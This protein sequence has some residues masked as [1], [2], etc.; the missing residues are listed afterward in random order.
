MVE[1]RAA[2]AAPG[3]TRPPEQHPSP[4]HPP[5]QVPVGTPGSAR[6]LLGQPVTE[7]EGAWSVCPPSGPARP[8]CKRPLAGPPGPSWGAGQ[9]LDWGAAARL[10]AGIGVVARLG[11]GGG[12][13]YVRVGGGAR[14]SARPDC[15]AAGR[16]PEPRERRLRHKSL[17]VPPSSFLPGSRLPLLRPP[18]LRPPL[19]APCSSP[20]R[21][22][23]AGAGGAGEGAGARICR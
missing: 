19:L 3:S 4:R 12:D 10:G 20:G 15:G 11:G 9:R 17:R 8:D 21:S 6:S 14:C 5:P 7:E 18:L 22:P 16:G 2:H 1:V 23:A 13:E